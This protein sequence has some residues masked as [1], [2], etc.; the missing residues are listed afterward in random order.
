MVLTTVSANTKSANLYI[1][2][3]P[4]QTTL[5]GT[6]DSLPECR[7]AADAFYIKELRDM[8]GAAAWIA[9]VCSPIQ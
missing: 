2:S 5:V 1:V 4:G 6:F 7:I 9:A 3:S 8:Q